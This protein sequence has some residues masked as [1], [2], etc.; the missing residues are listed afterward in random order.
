MDRRSFATL[1]EQFLEDPRT[2][3]IQAWDRIQYSV[4]IAALVKR[5]KVISR[6]MNKQGTR[7]SGCGY[8]NHGL[9]AEKNCVKQLGDI[10]KLR[11]ADMVVMRISRDKRREGFDRFL[12]SRPCPECELFLRKCMREYG[13]RNV[14]YTSSPACATATT[15]ATSSCQCR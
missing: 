15:T 8:S 12:E 3:R 2:E 13:L 10:S 11:G 4:H 7:S 5:G 1:L 14:Y 9:H 6:A